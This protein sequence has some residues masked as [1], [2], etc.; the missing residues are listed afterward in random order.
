M[1]L[2][3]VTYYQRLS[4]NRDQEAMISHTLIT[5]VIIYT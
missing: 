3:D 1:S 4:F 2:G 5:D